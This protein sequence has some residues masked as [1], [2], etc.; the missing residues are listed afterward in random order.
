MFTYVKIL[1]YEP[2][3]HQYY[4]PGFFKAPY[5]M[6]LPTENLGRAPVSPSVMMVRCVSSAQAFCE[7]FGALN[8]NDI[9]S[10]PNHLF[11]RLVYSL[12]VLT[13]ASRLDD[14]SAGLGSSSVYQNLS[15]ADVHMSLCL[16]KL[17]QAAGMTGEYRISSLFFDYAVRLR[18]WYLYQVQRKQASDLSEDPPFSLYAGPFDHP[19]LRGPFMPSDPAFDERTNLQQYQGIADDEYLSCDLLVGN[20]LDASFS[21]EG[22]MI[23]LSDMNF[24]PDFNLDTNSLATIDDP[25]ALGASVSFEWLE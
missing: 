24:D 1:L 3:L 6:E 7:T 4:S 21:Q 12:V 2:C 22:W 16:G 13:K 9:R 20:E 18:K 15:R 14:I 5:T 17:E 25:N 23:G 10:L 8:V 19:A 11:N